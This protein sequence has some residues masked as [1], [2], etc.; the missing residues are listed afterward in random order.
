VA[1]LDD[2]GYNPSGG[3]LSPKEAPMPQVQ[4]NSPAPDFA[5][6]DYRGKTFRLAD[7][8]GRNAA[9]LVFNRGF[10]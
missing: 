6:P 3:L 5:L 9:L 8:R 2:P 10:T 7:L 4:I 1:G